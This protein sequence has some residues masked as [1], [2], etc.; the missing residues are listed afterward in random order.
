M[1]DCEF[2]VGSTNHAPVVGCIED[3]LAPIRGYFAP[4]LRRGE[5][6]PMNANMDKGGVIRVG[7]NRMI[8]HPESLL[9][10]R[11]SGRLGGCFGLSVERLFLHHHLT[12]GLRFLFDLGLL[13][14]LDQNLDLFGGQSDTVSDK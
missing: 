8:E 11:A 13:E 4:H 9:A 1:I 5:V 2:L 6:H 3:T 7:P 12:L 14:R 10:I